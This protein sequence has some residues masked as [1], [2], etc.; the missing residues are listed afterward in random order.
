MGLALYRPPL[1]FIVGIK[2]TSVL[3]FRI[4]RRSLL[5]PNTLDKKQSDNSS[6]YLG[7]FPFESGHP[8]LSSGQGWI[9]T[10]TGLLTSVPR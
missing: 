5:H 3:A 7:G 6:P 9:V 8:G 4:E 10:G 1:G 2:I